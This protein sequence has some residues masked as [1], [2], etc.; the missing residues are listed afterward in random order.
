[1]AGLCRAVRIDVYGHTGV[2]PRQGIAG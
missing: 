2:P 1:M